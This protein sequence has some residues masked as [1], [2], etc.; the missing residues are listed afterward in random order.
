M[1][2]GLPGL[3]KR[4]GENA[5]ILLNKFVSEEEIVVEYG[6]GEHRILKQIKIRGGKTY[7]PRTKNAVAEL[8]SLI[9]GD[10]AYDERAN[11]ILGNNDIILIAKDDPGKIDL[12]KLAKTEEF[13]GKYIIGGTAAA[14]GGGVGTEVWSEI[15][16]M[17]CTS[18]YIVFGRAITREEFESNGDL[19]QRIY[20]K[21]SKIC[22][23]PSKLFSFT[24]TSKRKEL[25]TFGLSELKGPKFQGRKPIWLDSSIAQSEKIMNNNDITVSRDCHVFNDKFFGDGKNRYDP[26]TVYLSAGN[27]AQTDKWNPADMWIMN[28]KGMTSMRE[29]NRS[30]RDNPSVPALNTL[31]VK[32]WDDDNIFPISLKKLNPN[33][34]HWV[35]VNSNQYVERISI[36]RQTD[37][38]VIEFESGR[39]VKI[40]FVLETIKLK[41]KLEPKNIQDRIFGNIGTVVK[42]SQKSI[43]IKFKVSTRGLELEYQQ[44]K[45]QGGSAP[46]S[47]EAKMGA[48][49]YIEYNKIISNTSIE[50]I[51]ELNNIK[52]NYEDTNLNLDKNLNPF[53][54]H[55]VNIAAPNES[56]ARSYLQD[57][58]RA[59]MDMDFNTDYLGNTTALKDKIIAG[60]IG[61]SIHKIRNERVKKRVIQ[62]LYNACASVGI[63]GGVSTSDSDVNEVNEAITTGSSKTLNVEFLGGI[64]GKVY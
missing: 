46:K 59:I 6:K 8:F 55:G 30:R 38:L 24:I 14:G 13:G 33:S 15:L 36:D 52:D 47:A 11:P 64:H 37:P 12:T 51:R 21:V 4:G 41:D 44:T 35:V 61:V 19:I 40:N 57:I 5:I 23:I 3:R 53:T 58:Y 34:P 49:G 27:T 63:M 28:R 45:P 16:S 7:T 56:T 32:E 29:F 60:E 50:G 2:I 26:Y 54:S 1:G 25:V 42:G 10:E 17:Y 39:D 20:S 31:L 9:A 62:N 43:R 22:H 48:L 18:F